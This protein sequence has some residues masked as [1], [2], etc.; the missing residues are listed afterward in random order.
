[1]LS[2]SKM[3]KMWRKCFLPISFGMGIL[4]GCAFQPPANELT[5]TSALSSASGDIS[6]EDTGKLCTLNFGTGFSGDVVTGETYSTWTLASTLDTHAAVARVKQGLDIL[7]KT[8]ATK[9]KITNPMRITGE[10]YHSTEASLNFFL[11]NVQLLSD[12]SLG[13]RIQADALKQSLG[14]AD[15]TSIAGLT[16]PIPFHMDMDAALGEISLGIYLNPSQESGYGISHERMQWLACSVIAMATDTPLPSQP[17]TSQRHFQNPFKSRQAKAQEQQREQEDILAT[18]KS[19]RDMLYRRALANGKA[20]IVV[21]VLSTLKKYQQYS[22]NEYN[23]QGDLYPQYWADNTATLIWQNQQDPKSFLKIGPST[24]DRDIGLRG[25]VG[26]WPAGRE[27]YETYIVNPGT[28][29]LVGHSVEHARQSIP[30]VSSKQWKAKSPIGVVSLTGIQ[31]TEFYSAQQWYNPEY[32]TVTNTYC[33]ADLFMNGGYAGCASWQTDQNQVMTNP[34]GMR[35]VIRKKQI[36]GIGV[37]T[38][39]STPFASF[40]LQA[41][42]V[43]V[44]DGFL[45]NYNNVTYDAKACHQTGETQISCDIS[46]YRLSLIPGQVDVIRNAMTVGPSLLT[47]TLNPRTTMQAGYLPAS[48]ERS[49]LFLSKLQYLPLQIKANPGKEIPGTYE[50]GWTKPYVLH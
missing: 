11:D 36:N 16:R 20:V 10:D 40:K 6:A 33:T 22:P 9:L 15:G 23:H 18:I 8:F 45:V 1:M 12:E 2:N 27:E 34:G 47:G 44:T 46:L 26:S 7:N 30:E 38:S 35:D 49:K 5:P 31:N 24:S 17:G 50:A 43:V 25:Y 32:K 4:G 13:R 19:A 39:L 42:Q 3:L 48:S 21:P 29:N 14:I 41:G 28:W 37:A